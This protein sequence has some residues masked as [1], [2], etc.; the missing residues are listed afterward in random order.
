MVFI[1]GQSRRHGTPLW[2]TLTTQLPALL[3]PAEV[4][5]IQRDS[6]D[7]NVVPGEQKQ[8]TINHMLA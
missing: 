4:I 6:G 5:L 7:N 8:F 1:G 2:L 3:S